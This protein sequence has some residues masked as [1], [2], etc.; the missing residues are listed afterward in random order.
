ML[1]WRPLKEAALH[2]SCRL[3]SPVCLR[4][5]STATAKPKQK[6]YHFYTVLS[7]EP[8]ATPEQIK[9]AYYELSKV[10]H[11]DKGGGDESELKFTLISEAYETLSN[12]EARKSVSYTHLT[13]PTICSV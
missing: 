6:P 5:A 11:P 9:E 13:L 3:L 7:V 8:T 2:P 10:H 12:P 4:H 1:G